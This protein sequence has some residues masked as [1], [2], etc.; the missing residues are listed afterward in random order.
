MSQQ[1]VTKC[2]F[3]QERTTATGVGQIASIFAVSNSFLMGVEIVHD[4]PE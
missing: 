4:V 1:I 2:H 3:L